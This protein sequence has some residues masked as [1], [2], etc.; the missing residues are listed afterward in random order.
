MLLFVFTPMVC[1]FAFTFGLVYLKACALA[2]Q[3]TASSLP[4]SAENSVI[5]FDL[6]RVLFFHD[7]KRMCLT[8]FKSPL[9]WRLMSAM[10]N[11]CLIRDMIKLLYRRPIPES[12]FVHLSHSY[13]SVRDIMP[14]L[15]DIANQQK[16]NE[17]TIKIVKELKAQGFELAVLSNIGLRIFKALEP[18]HPDLFSLFDYILVATPETDY[19]SKPNPKVYVRLCATLNSNKHVV[20]VDD[21]EK[22][23][24]GALPFG[25]IGIIYKKPEQLKKQLKKLGVSIA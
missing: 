1:S 6:H 17:E 10:I 9:K 15:I 2:N 11:P 14:L 19:I 16:R 24:C 20:L 8:F 21:Q 4:L 12:F 5:V 25:I 13:A 7:Y 18:K 22:N 23:I 3:S